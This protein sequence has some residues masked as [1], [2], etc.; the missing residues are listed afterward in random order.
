MSV[1]AGVEGTYLIGWE[2]DSQIYSLPALEVG[3]QLGELAT[4]E[5]GLLDALALLVAIVV[6]QSATPESGPAAVTWCV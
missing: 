1:H 5:G 3:L 4:V 2:R 6:K